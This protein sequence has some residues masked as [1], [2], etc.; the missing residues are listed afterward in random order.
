[1]MYPMRKT[2]LWFLKNVNIDQEISL[3]GMYPKGLKTQTN[4]CT[5][6]F[7]A[8]LVTIAKMWKM[9]QTAINESMDTQMVVS[10]YN[11]VLFN[12]THK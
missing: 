3:L 5:H 10:I 8:A 11:G 2:V 9:A 7:T 12:H 1:M 4:T 6:M